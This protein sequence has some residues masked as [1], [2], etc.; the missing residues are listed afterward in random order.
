MIEIPE[1]ESLSRQITEAVTGK[2]IAGVVAGLSPHKFAWY[3]GDPKDYDALLREKTID[4]AVARGGM[5][6]IRAG[7]AVLLFSDGVVLRFHTRDEQRPQK[8]QLLIEFEDATAISASVQMYGGLWCFKEGEF[9]N[10]YYDTARSKPSP[11]SDEFDKAYFDGLI[12][13]SDV[14]KLS[15]KAFLATEQRIPGLGNGVLQDILYKARV[16]PKRKVETLTEGERE[17]LFNSVKSTL[18]EMTA[19]GGRDT[20]KDL[21]GEP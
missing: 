2:R 21:F 19:Q 10:P 18:K 4:T 12:T 8:H 14:Q 7:N 5:L 17:T 9:H 6:E 3:H 1:A 15:A 16:H 20:E 11:L 13:S